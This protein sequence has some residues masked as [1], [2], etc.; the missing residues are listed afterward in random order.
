MDWA[1]ISYGVFLVFLTV[2]PFLIRV[3]WGNSGKDS[4]SLRNFYMEELKDLKA[5]FDSGK[6]NESEF[7]ELASDTVRKIKGVSEASVPQADNRCTQCGSLIELPS[8]KFCPECGTAVSR[9]L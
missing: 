8:A 1:V 9:N 4:A 6:L 3:R 5:E 2:S 7:R